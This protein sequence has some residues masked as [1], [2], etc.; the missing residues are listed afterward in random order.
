MTSARIPVTN[1]NDSSNPPASAPMRFEPSARALSAHTAKERIKIR[2]AKNAGAVRNPLAAISLVAP[3]NELNESS[4]TSASTM[5]VAASPVITTHCGRRG[6][7]QA[8]RLASKIITNTA[9]MT[10]ALT[11]HVMPNNS[12]ARLTVCTSSNRNAA[13]SAKKCQSARVFLCSARRPAVITAKRMHPETI[14][15]SLGISARLRYK[16]GQS[17]VVGRVVPGGCNWQAVTNSR[18]AGS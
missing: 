7:R 3:V 15:C 17:S 10:M 2:P 9:E 16:Y 6:Q 5:T 12:V 18:K 8:T 14:R 1:D 13:P 4:G 11:T